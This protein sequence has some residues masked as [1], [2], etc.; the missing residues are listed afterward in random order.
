MPTLK[1]SV[2]LIGVSGENL[3]IS[4]DAVRT[5]PEAI[6]I[7]DQH[8]YNVIVVAPALLGKD[9]I[10]SFNRLRERNPAVQVVLYAPNGQDPHQLAKMIESLE[11][12]RV[13]DGSQLQ[14]DILLTLERAQEKSQQSHLEK[15]V[16]EQKRE[17]KGTLSRS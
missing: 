3:T 11:A 8:N 17:T 14:A 7:I 10:S 4:A 13:S 16:Q 5:A 15:L 6:K 9:F 1:S 12:L 2:L